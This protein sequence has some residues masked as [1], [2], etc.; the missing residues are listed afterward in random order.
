M[1]NKLALGVILSLLMNTATVFGATSTNDLKISNANVRLSTMN[2]L[3][4]QR[5]RIYATV[6]NTGTRDLLGYVRFFDG[7]TQIGGDQPISVVAAKDD[8]VFIDWTPVPG[9][10]DITV[11]IVPFDKTGDIP[12]NNDATKEVTVLSDT[13]R[14][15]VAN[16]SDSDDDNDGINDQE[17]QFPLDKNEH[18]DTDGDGQGDNKDADDDND[19]TPDATDQVPHDASETIDTDKDGIGNNQDSDDDNDGLLDLEELQKGTDPLK[20]D[21]DG[22]G[23]NDKDDAFPLDPKYSKDSDRDGIA[24]ELDQ[25]ADNDGIPKTADINDSNQGPEINITAD[26]QKSA[27]KIVYPDE[28]V[29]FDTGTSFDLDGKIASISWKVENQ[30]LKGQQ[31]KTTFRT[32]G[33]KTVAVTVTDDKGESREKIFTVYVVPQATPWYATG[34]FV[35]ILAL[36]IWIVLFYSRRRAKKNKRSAAK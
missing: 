13:D 28:I 36:A 10:H 25:D 17:D 11:R 32:V 16:D 22:G 26:G 2:L 12:S 6:E 33:Q 23:V 7:Q 1:K 8:T 27:R 21:T 20:Y 3:E 35:L 31:I 9:D 14:D 4:G 34:F 24:D 29:T 18:V 15:G 5:V 30:E 19:N